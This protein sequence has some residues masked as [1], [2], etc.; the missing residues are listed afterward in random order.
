VHPLSNFPPPYTLGLSTFFSF[1]L[2]NQFPD[3]THTRLE[4]VFKSAYFQ[5]PSLLT[6][7][8]FNTGKPVFFLTEF[9]GHPSR[10]SRNYSPLQY[11][12][13]DPVPPHPSCKLS[14]AHTTKMCRCRCCHDLFRSGRSPLLSNQVSYSFPFANREIDVDLFF[15]FFFFFFFFM[16]PPMCRPPPFS[17][18]PKKVSAS[19]LFFLRKAWSFS[20]SDEFEEYV[21]VPSFFSPPS[22]V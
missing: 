9:T 21:F 2:A 4:G 3:P 5:A 17:P 19:C 1:N 12:S 18:P 20:P 22:F 6:F 15:C 8:S 13:H 10:G 11:L 16:A 7:L 14:C